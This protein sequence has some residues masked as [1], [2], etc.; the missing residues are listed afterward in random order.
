VITAILIG[1]GAAACWAVSVYI[2][3]FRP[4]GRCGGTGHKPGSTRR[5]F[6]LCHRCGGTGRRQRTGSATAHRTVLAI[7]TEI[8]RD[9][10]RAGRQAAMRSTHPP[11]QGPP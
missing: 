6:G 8:G 3:P 2:Y 7:T 5:R 9:R 10:R 4:C 1:L 11:Q